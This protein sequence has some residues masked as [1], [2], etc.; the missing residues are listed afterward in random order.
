MTTD[1]KKINLR[2]FLSE[3]AAAWL[4]LLRIPFPLPGRWL[5]RS[6]LADGAWAYPLIGALIGFLGGVV[7]FFGD[8]LELSPVFSSGLSLGAMILV[9]GALHEDGLADFFDSFGG[10]DQARRLEIMRD[11]RI[12]T[13]GTLGLILSVGLR[14]GALLALLNPFVVIGVLIA[15]GA[16]SRMVCLILLRFLAPAR[17]DGLGASA[18]GL[19]MPVLVAGGAITVVVA[20][21]ALPLL[22]TL[23]LIATTFVISGFMMVL[24]K[25]RFGGYTGDVLGAGQQFA[26]IAILIFATGLFS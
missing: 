13:F 2:R 1:G 16:L 9:T 15:A 20:G 25:S 7:Y 6:S 26:E 3:F 8:W 22:P 24:A 12:G 19:T 23:Y 18:T 17:S 4:L 10:H 5:D 11:S 21:I 14:W